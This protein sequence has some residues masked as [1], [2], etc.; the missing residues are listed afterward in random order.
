[1]STAVLQGGCVDSRNQTLAL[2]FMALGQRDVSKLL[3]GDLTTYTIQFLRHL[4]DFFQVIYRIELH[5]TTKHSDSKITHEKEEAEDDSEEEEVA[6][7]GPKYLMSCVGTGY[8]NLNKI[9]S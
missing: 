7:T 8:T 3:L 2:L 6:G 9:T 1:M 4:R 5:H